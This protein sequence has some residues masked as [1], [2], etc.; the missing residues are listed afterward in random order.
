MFHLYFLLTIQYYENNFEQTFDTLFHHKIVNQKTQFA[1]FF[2][3][4]YFMIACEKK[5]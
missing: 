2:D 4:R 1:A 3:N 5:N